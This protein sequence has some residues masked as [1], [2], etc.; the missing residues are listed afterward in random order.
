LCDLFA[1]LASPSL[2]IFLPDNSLAALTD[3]DT[4][5]PNYFPLLYPQRCPPSKAASA[6]TLTLPPSL[7]FFNRS[8]LAL[9]H[10]SLQDGPAFTMAGKERD[11]KQSVGPGPG[12]YGIVNP[13]STKEVRSPAY[14]MPGR[15]NQS[16]STATPG[17]AAYNTGPSRSTGPAVSMKGSRTD[18]MAGRTQT[19]GPIYS[20]S[21][22]AK[23]SRT[24]SAPA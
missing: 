23:L 10:A 24:A 8:S 19:P 1:G 16:T 15:G 9:R 6:P 4:C 22:P 21:D 17:P 13:Q 12:A 18:V 5:T 11:S 3:A 7:R 14:T 20:P 2:L